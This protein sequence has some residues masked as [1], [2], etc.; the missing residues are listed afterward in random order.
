[1]KQTD[2]L[3]KLD[4]QLF[5]DEPAQEKPENKVDPN[6]NTIE[7][8]QRLK[9][10]SVSKEDY[11]KLEEQNRQ[12]LDAIINGSSI[13]QEVVDKPAYQGSINDL[14]AELYGPKRKEMTNL[15]Y[16]SKTLLLRDM[17]ME[18]GKTDPFVPVGRK[19]QATYADYESANK[20]YVGLKKCVEAADGD[21]VAF[22]AELR[23]LGL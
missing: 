18:Q 21:P 3:F 17:L 11:E 19:V 9:A 13:N 22:N 1:M 7:A 12:L 8:L 14:R 16:V 10:N 6:K 15:E 2:Y 23:K 4:L 5:A 20:V